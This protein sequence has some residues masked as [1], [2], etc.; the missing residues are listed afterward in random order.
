MN[1]WTGIA[2]LIIGLVLIWIG[3]P[4]KTGLHPSFLR[5]DAAMVVYPPIILAF[6]TMGAAAVIELALEVRPLSGR[7][8]HFQPKLIAPCRLLALGVV[9]LLRRNTSAADSGKL[10]ARHL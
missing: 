9:L 3:R 6:I 8:F 2:M 4:D 10:S 7:L 5:F 1:L